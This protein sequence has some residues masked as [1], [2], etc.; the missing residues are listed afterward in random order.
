MSKS[1]LRA[2]HHIHGHILAWHQEEGSTY[3]VLQ[4]DDIFIVGGV[5][6]E[7]SIVIPTRNG[8]A[9]CDSLEAAIH[10]AREA[11]RMMTQH[12]EAESEAQP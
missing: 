6:E 10:I 7:A 4:F 11:N 1:Y 2:E 12:T 5:S 3:G 9:T 8:L